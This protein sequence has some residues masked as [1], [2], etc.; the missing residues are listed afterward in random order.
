MGDMADYLLEMSM[1]D[2]L[3]DDFDRI[4][5]QI[6]CK[7]CGEHGLRWRKVGEHWRLFDGN[8]RHYC[9]PQHQGKPE[10]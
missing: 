2:D 6:V 5:K 4:P 1:D 9:K 8:Q 10:L 3:Y 7:W